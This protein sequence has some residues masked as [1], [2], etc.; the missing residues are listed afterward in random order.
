MCIV[1]PSGF[2]TAQWRKQEFGAQNDTL[3]AMR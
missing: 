2:P 1:G 3:N